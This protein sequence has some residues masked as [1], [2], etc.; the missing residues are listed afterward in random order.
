MRQFFQ[1]R[2]EIDAPYRRTFLVTMLLHIIN[3]YDVGYQVI[4]GVHKVSLQFKK[5]IKK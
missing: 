1:T 4:Q 2:V 5:N 3:N